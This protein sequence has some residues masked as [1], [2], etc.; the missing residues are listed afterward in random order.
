VLPVAILAAGRREITYKEV[1]AATR[2]FDTSRVIGN[3]AFG[4]VC[5]GFVPESRT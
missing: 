2:G 3:G 5:K 4:V 1:S